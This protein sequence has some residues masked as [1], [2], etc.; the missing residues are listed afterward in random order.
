MTGFRPFFNQATGEWIEF[1]AGEAR[2]TLDG[3]ELT[4]RAG[5][6]VVV[7]A[8]VR[9][10]EGNPGPAEV[11]ATVELLHHPAASMTHQCSASAPPPLPESDREHLLASLTTIQAQLNLTAR[12]PLPAAKPRRRPAPSVS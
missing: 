8:G 1:T 3:E 4:A 2:F 9:H 7:P 6:T 12:Q 5:D 11:R 10:S